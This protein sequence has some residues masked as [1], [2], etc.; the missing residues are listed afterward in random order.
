MTIVACVDRSDHASEIIAEAVQ[1]AEAFDEPIHAVN[2]LTRDQFVNLQR[3]SV[4]DTGQAVSVEQVEELATEIAAEALE[5]V[6]AVGEAVGLVGKPA[7]EIVSYAE[8]NDS[9]YIVL[10]GRNRSLVGKALF[11]SVAQSVLLD[12]D[13]PAVIVH[14]K[15]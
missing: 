1:L 14:S 11:G 6:G 15:E 5:S 4:S 7:E 13:R 8:A 10:G 2:V 12:S 3:T 9:R